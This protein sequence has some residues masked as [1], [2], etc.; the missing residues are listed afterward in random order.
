[1][2]QTPASPVKAQPR[3]YPRFEATLWTRRLPLHLRGTSVARLFEPGK[4]GGKT[5]LPPTRFHDT[6]DGRAALL[7]WA[8]RNQQPDLEVEFIRGPRE[9]RRRIHLSVV[10][11]PDFVARGLEDRDL[12]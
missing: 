6:V 1:L 5:R 9:H 4:I 8:R 7:L 2:A 12:R 3:D 10:F 11:R